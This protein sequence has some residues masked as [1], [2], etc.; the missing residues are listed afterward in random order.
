MEAQM[1]VEELP[2][3]D[4]APSNAFALLHA[5]PSQWKAACSEAIH[6]S[7]GADP[8]TAL[9][10]STEEEQFTTHAVGPRGRR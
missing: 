10:G 8:H 3:S 1:S 4:S 2:H 6:T 5:T 9:S 7:F